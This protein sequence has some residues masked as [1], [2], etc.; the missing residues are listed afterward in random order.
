MTYFLQIE[1]EEHHRY[2]LLN[3]NEIVTI[4]EVKD[5]TSITMKNGLK[6]LTK[7]PYNKIRDGIDEMR[8]RAG[9]AY[10]E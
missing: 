5:G 10:R 1:L 3:L 8:S 4:V 2:A 7:T 9:G 6:I